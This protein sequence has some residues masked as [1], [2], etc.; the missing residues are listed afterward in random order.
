MEIGMSAQSELANYMSTSAIPKT[1]RGS[2]IDAGN[3]YIGQMIAHD[4]VIPTTAPSNYFRTAEWALNLDSLY[5]HKTDGESPYLTDG[6]FEFSTHCTQAQSVPTDSDL[7]RNSAGEVQIPDSRNDE[8]TLVCQ[9]Q[10]FWQKLHNHLVNKYNYNASEA[11]R[12]VT[13]TFQLVVIE[14]FLRDVL[15][16]NRFKTFFD[17]SSSFSLF[18]ASDDNQIK[19]DLW[20]RHKNSK[21][22]PDFFSKAAFRFGHSLVRPK[23]F[24]NGNDDHFLR[25]LF[26]RNMNLEK[27]FVVDWN[28]F[29]AGQNAASI[30]TFI[31]KSMNSVPNHVGTPTSPDNVPLLN[32]KASGCFTGYGLIEQLKQ[33]SKWSDVAQKFN[34][35]KLTQN[36]LSQASFNK[37]TLKIAELPLWPY[38]LLE[39]QIHSHGAYLGPLGALLNAEVLKAAIQQANHSVWENNGTYN[40]DN[41]IEQLGRFGE[42]LSNSI[43]LIP[44]RKSSKKP[45]MLALISIVREG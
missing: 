43:N 16:K 38:L 5:G 23:Y 32:L 34:V 22:V 7:R 4:I 2:N 10:V 37:C 14:D 41:S 35:C 19:S 31:S 30:D 44:P 6:K 1:L 45:V 33:L 26:R 42:D 3:T 12:A 18:E 25:D 20:T 29:F 40:F 24:V 11:R 9:L 21:T 39:A 28:Q 36:D 17:P 27:K 8:N 15:G 13:L